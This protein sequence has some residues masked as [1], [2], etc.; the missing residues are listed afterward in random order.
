MKTNQQK[1]GEEQ[2]KLIYFNYGT[3]HEFLHYF[4]EGNVKK[5][6]KVDLNA[7]LLNF[8]HYIIL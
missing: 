2:F 3:L 6:D 5:T 8:E 7:I 1:A 4:T